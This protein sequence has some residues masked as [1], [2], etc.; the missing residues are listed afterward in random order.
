MKVVKDQLATVRSAP[1]AA[2]TE[3]AGEGMSNFIA[4]QR[5]LLQLVQRQNDIVMTGVEERAGGSAPAAAATGL[6]R[7]SIDTFI[8]MQQHFLTT[9]AKQADAWIDA[10][11]AGKPFPGK[12]LAELAREA[13]ETFVRSQKKFLDVV[14]EETAK[15]TGANGH[16]AAKAAKKTE[17]SELARQASE[18]LIDAQKKVLDVAAQQV[19]VNVK[20]VRETV[21][22][23]NPFRPA[24]LSQFTRETVDNLVDA[25]KALLDVVAK[26]RRTAAPE[27]R[28]GGTRPKPRARKAPRKAKR[29]TEAVPV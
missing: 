12:G 9:A 2:L 20:T 5:V 8:D 28:E 18:A 11:K 4:A 29:E 14:A 3:M 7:R 25:Q 15:A 10:T 6:V 1:V 17:L 19:A 26:P 16:A 22:V 21:D 24:V 23:M 13:M 27:A